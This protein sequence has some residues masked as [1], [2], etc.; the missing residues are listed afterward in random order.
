MEY[1]KLVFKTTHANDGTVQAKQTKQKRT[2]DV[3][4]TSSSLVTFLRIAV[5]SI[6]LKVKLSPTVSCSVSDFLHPG[7]QTLPITIVFFRML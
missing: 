4:A 1:I 6:F 7:S 3:R 5:K 2:K